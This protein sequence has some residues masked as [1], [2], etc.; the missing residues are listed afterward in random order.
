MPSPSWVEPFIKKGT[1]APISTAMC[2]NSFGLRLNYESTNP[3][4][5]L[6]AFE[7]PPPNPLPGGIFFQNQY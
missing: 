7:D 5:I 4:I 3:F 6:A 2:S 1:S